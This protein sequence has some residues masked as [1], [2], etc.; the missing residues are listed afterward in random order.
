MHK[1]ENC[2]EEEYAK[3]CDKNQ[4]HFTNIENFIHI[5][6][7]WFEQTI[8]NVKYNFEERKTTLSPEKMKKSPMKGIGIQSFKDSY[9]D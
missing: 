9:E 7:D 1:P 3:F 2:S 5:V 8:D 4:H 6:N